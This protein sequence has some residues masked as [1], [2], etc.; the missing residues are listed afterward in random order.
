MVR[1]LL[2]EAAEWLGQRGD[3][4]WSG[5]LCVVVDTWGQ[6]RKLSDQE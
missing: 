6:G 4:G 1:G 3:V 5:D 2:R